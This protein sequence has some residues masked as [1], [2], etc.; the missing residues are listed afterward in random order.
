MALSGNR[1]LKTQKISNEAVAFDETAA[2]SHKPTANIAGGAVCFVVPLFLPE[3]AH[4]QKVINGSP[5]ITERVDG[6]LDSV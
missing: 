2:G 3:R 6:P 5:P 1:V 4:T